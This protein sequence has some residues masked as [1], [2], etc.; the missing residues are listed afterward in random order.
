MITSDDCLA[1]WSTKQQ[2]FIGGWASKELIERARAW[3]SRSSTLFISPKAVFRPSGPSVIN[4]SL[5][6]ILWPN[7]TP[8]DSLGFAVVSTEHDDEDPE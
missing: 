5:Q 7:N 8:E 4:K 2:P 6:K 1:V 3:D